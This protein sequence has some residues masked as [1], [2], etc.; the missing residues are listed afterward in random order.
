MSNF[1]PCSCRGLQSHNLRCPLHTRRY[2]QLH[3]VQSK[4]NF[5]QLV[6]VANT[7]HKTTRILSTVYVTVA[8]TNWLIFT[9]VALIIFLTH[10]SAFIGCVFLNL[11]GPRLLLWYTRP[12]RMCSVVPWPTHV[13]C[14]PSK[15]PSV[16]RVRR[17][18]CHQASGSQFHYWQPG[19]F[20]CWPPGVELSAAGGYAGVIV[21]S[22]VHVFDKLTHS[23]KDVSVYWVTFWLYRLI[24]CVYILSVVDLAVF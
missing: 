4:P 7:K 17:R 10:S 18:L 13:R 21:T 12:P 24:L 19:I 20:G 5:L 3:T 2:L 22:T 16:L 1:L 6:L 23:L 8:I 9:F 15:S 11:S 14:R